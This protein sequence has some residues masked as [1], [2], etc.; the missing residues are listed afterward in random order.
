MSENTEN[1]NYAAMSDDELNA[2]LEE[3][4]FNAIEEPTPEEAGSA[5]DLDEPKEEADDDTTADTD[6]ETNEETEEK[7]DE[8]SDDNETSAD[9]NTKPDDEGSDEAGEKTDEQSNEDDKEKITSPKLEDS[10]FKVKGKEIPFSELKNVESL[11]QKGLGFGKNRQE[12]AKYQ[13]VF[14][15]FEDNDITS[16]ED[17]NT[18][19][20]AFKGNKQAIGSLIK[21]HS[22]EFDS[23]DDDTEEVY[24]P[25]NN[26][27]SENSSKVVV[28]LSEY[29]D[30]DTYNELAEVTR[31]KFGTENDINFIANNPE[32]IDMLQAHVKD[33]FYEKAL[34]R[35]KQVRQM[36]WNIPKD[37]SDSQIYFTE[38]N[39]LIQN[40]QAETQEAGV[41]KTQQASVKEALKPNK[42]KK[43]VTKK[44]TIKKP[45]DMTDEELGKYLQK[46]YSIN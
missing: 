32:F 16:E 18:L 23:F 25:N 36:N 26:L 27:Y 43:E 1:T 39:A 21:K 24:N 4:Y 41:K 44:Q 20:D 2:S 13:R 19:I 37:I 38:V 34:N 8:Q 42:G 22:I 17:Y 33:G 31:K 35:V 9:T 3:K 11:I 10:V 46:K 14:K 7:K 5:I 29:K 28:A 12:F 30:T 6:T 15:S 40:Q 45:E